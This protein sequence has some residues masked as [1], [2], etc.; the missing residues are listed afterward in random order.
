MVCCVLPYRLHNF[1]WC[2]KSCW[3]SAKSLCCIYVGLGATMRECA[4]S[5][6]SD[7]EVMQVIEVVVVVVVVVVL[8]IARITRMVFLVS[9]VTSDLVATVSW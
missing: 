8:L 9:G 7:G 5:C 4:S 1:S 2:A 6:D 3:W